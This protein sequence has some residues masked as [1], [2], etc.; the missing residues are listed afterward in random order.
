MTTV[1]ILE[2][3]FES[4]RLDLIKKHDELGMRS[5]GQWAD[6]L[7]STVK[8]KGSSTI[9]KIEGVHYTEQLQFGRRPGKFPPI[10]AIEDWIVNKGIQ[11]IEENISIS[12]LAFLIARKIA[13]EGT[14]YFQQGG[15][16]LIDSVINARRIQDI[17]DKVTEINVSAIVTGF[18]EQL[19]QVA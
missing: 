11:P 19:K 1:E 18:V 3:E 4:I 9:A 6:S 8:E 7:Q 16:D 10:K 5:S 13:Q 14:T 15:T 12:S 17:L 2:I